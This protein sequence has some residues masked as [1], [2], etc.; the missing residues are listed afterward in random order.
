MKQ[1]EDPRCLDRKALID[2]IRA[3]H[4][5]TLAAVTDL[6]D[7]QWMVPYDPGIQPVAW[8]LAHIG[9][10]YEF[11]ALRGP[12]GITADGIVSAAR[13][14]RHFPEDERYDSARVAHQERWV[15][16]LYSRTDVIA[17][18]A[19]AVDE[20]CEHIAALDDDSDA[21]LYFARLGLY[22]ELMHH[23]ALLW[24]RD[25]LAYPGLAD[26]GMRS[27]EAAPPIEFPGGA[28]VLGRP[29]GT[30][31]FAFDNEMPGRGV[32]LEPFDIDAQPVTNGQF[33]AFVEAGGYDRADY[34]TGPAERFRRGLDRD[35][36][37]RWRRGG[38]SGFEQRWFD[39]WRELASDEPVI[40]V[41]CFE[42]EAYCR[43]IGRRL[44]TAAEWE[45][46]ADSV[47]WG[48]SVWEW[49]ATPLAPY[50][51]FRPG[52]YV[53]YSAPWFHWQREMRGGAFATDGLMHD[54]TYRNFFLPQ[55]TDVFAG[56]RTAAS[57]PA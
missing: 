3:A 9:W 57:R 28:V 55:R 27:V 18:L 50:P 52:P 31:G 21:T 10:A 26:Y 15:M 56:F 17:R 39:S 11:W 53:T 51:G 1:L 35:H 16:P 42:A 44:P 32:E 25:L 48:R 33:R 14:G 19:N 22:H 6:S 38:G 43:H 49:T 29:P 46:A 30:P 8:D 40:H 13:P 34:W 41:S 45:A 12:H 24:T 4:G 37:T 20:C 7:A 23:E 47:D 5:R 36:P 2:A 54:R